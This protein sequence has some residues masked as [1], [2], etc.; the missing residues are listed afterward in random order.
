MLAK[1]FC[2]YFS[3][4]SAVRRIMVAMKREEAQEIAIAVC[5]SPHSLRDTKAVDALSVRSAPRDNGLPSQA[6][7]AVERFPLNSA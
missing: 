2:F 5:D 7:V 4:A 6:L 3:V 1:R